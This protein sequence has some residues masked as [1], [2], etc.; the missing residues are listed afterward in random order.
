MSDWSGER[1]LVTGGRRGLGFAYARR[2]AELGA[3]V[4][5]TTRRPEDVGA[6]VRTL[7]WDMND[8]ESTSRLE[9]ALKA[10]PPSIVIHAAHDFPEHVPT[11]GLRADDIAGAVS[12]HVAA[13]YA[14]IRLAS[15]LMMRAAR[16]RIVVLSSLAVE[17][18]PP[19][20]A[21]YVASKLAVDGIARVLASEVHG[22]GVGVCVVRPGIVDT[23]NVRERV[24][25]EARR[26][27]GELSG[28]G[29]LLT[30]DE[31]VDATLPHLDPE[32]AVP[33]GTIVRVGAFRA[34]FATD[35]AFS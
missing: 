24:S 14:L 32:G 18:S 19:G 3:D 12:R 35:G 10:D 29:R 4:R 27:Y 26:A 25:A 33:N 17:A 34:E 22:R 28:L 15:R 20:Q 31:V 8:A 30:V 6:G 11:V 13:S 16:G 2:L 7:V 23:E 9:A 21:A 5:I 1:V